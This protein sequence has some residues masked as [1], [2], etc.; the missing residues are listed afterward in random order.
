[1]YFDGAYREETQLADGTRVRLRLVVPADK[2]QLASAFQRLSPEARYLRFF[3]SKETLTPGELVYLTE[4]DQ[5]QHFALGAAALNEAGEEGEGLGIARFVRLADR[6]ETAESAVVVADRVKG[7][8]LGRLLLQRLVA[9][10]VERGVERFRCEVLA[11]N[12][13]MRGLL[14]Q[15][16]PEADLKAE[17]EVVVLEWDLPL[18]P[19]DQAAG[20]APRENGLYRLL[21]LAAE[22]AVVVRQ[23][24]FGGEPPPQ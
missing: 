13:A 5:A 2:T 6:P 8:G 22:G 4:M 10:A 7:R 11:G 16:A 9:A 24:L 3:A 1:M 21:Q 17:G 23:W 15:L 20:D 14:G 12:D 18:V 19:H